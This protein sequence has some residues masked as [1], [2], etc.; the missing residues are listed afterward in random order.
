MIMSL[1]TLTT[2][3]Q[4]LSVRQFARCDQTASIFPTTWRR[5]Q[6][7][8]VNAFCTGIATGLMKQNAKVRMLPVA[9]LYHMSGWL[10]KRYQKG[11]L[12]V[13]GCGQETET[14]SAVVSLDQ[15]TQM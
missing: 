8:L 11:L 2:F 9:L 12:V 10:K 14:G 1:T 4:Q 3:K 7:M 5:R 13:R 6:S 15:S